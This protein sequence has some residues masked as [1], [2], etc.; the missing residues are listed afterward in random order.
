MILKK[1]ILTVLIMTFFT[2]CNRISQQNTDSLRVG[3]PPK[4]Y[5]NG[6]T[7]LF[8]APDGSVQI[9]STLDLDIGAAW[10]MSSG[11]DIHF[12][13]RSTSSSLQYLLRPTN[14]AV[15]LLMQEEDE[16]GYFKCKENIPHLSRMSILEL[17]E[18]E[19]ICLLTSEGRL[20]QLHIDH[21]NHLGEGSIRLSHIIWD[22]VFED[23]IIALATTDPIPTL[24]PTET[25]LPLLPTRTPDPSEAVHQ[26]G[27]IRLHAN[28]QSLN[29]EDSLLNLDWP[30]IQD[31]TQS[32][33]QFII[34]RGGGGRYFYYFM[35]IHG[36]KGRGA[37]F[38]EP[39]IEGCTAIQ[40]D[41]A[42]VIIDDISVGNFICVL[43]NQ[44]RMAQVRIEDINLDQVIEGWIE[45]SYQTWE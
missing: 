36:A 18:G 1:V 17:S 33:I 5:R 31:T 8:V 34:S 24:I 21:L 22:E 9:D 7:P 6:S 37:G 42:P 11:Y 4:F 13:A 32:D 27:T 12:S 15:A 29:E 40:E 16:P 28:F 26:A 41:L 23:E 20:G 2:S 30:A 35:M 45:I 10:V 44:N 38:V 3:V 25:P 43:T 39:G 19:Y 14:G